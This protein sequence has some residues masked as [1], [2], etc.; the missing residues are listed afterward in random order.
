MLGVVFC[1]MW[2]S[3]QKG[4]MKD[5]L[6]FALVVT[7]V[8]LFAGG[9]KLAFM[10]PRPYDFFPPEIVIRTLFARPDTYSFPSGHSAAAF[11]AAVLLHFFY[12]RAARFV[13]PAAFIVAI[14]RIFIGVHYPSD[15]AAGAFIGILGGWLGVWILK[16]SD[17]GRLSKR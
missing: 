11:A 14:S 6:A 4:W 16:H 12:G 2:I 9:L 17:P 15:V 10:R 13:Y 8:Y 5:Y 1:V 7:I 3:R